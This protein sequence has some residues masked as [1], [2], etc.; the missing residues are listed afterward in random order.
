[1]FPAATFKVWSPTSGRIYDRSGSSQIRDESGSE[2]IR[3]EIANRKSEEIAFGHQDMSVSFHDRAMVRK[4][5]LK[6]IGRVT[7]LRF[8]GVAASY[9]CMNKFVLFI[10][11][12]DFPCAI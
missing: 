11:K 8:C 6:K 7:E 1:M 9:G 12:Q 10:V 4:I 5:K 3:D 2:L